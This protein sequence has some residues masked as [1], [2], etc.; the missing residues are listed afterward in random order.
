[1]EAG[2]DRLLEERE[3]ARAIAAARPRARGVEGVDALAE[4][5][6]EALAQLAR[7]LDRA[8]GVEPSSDALERGRAD[9]L[10]ALLRLDQADELVHPARLGRRA[11]DG[12]G[13][14]VVAAVDERLDQRGERLARRARREEHAAL[15]ERVRAH[16]GGEGLERGARAPGVA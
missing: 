3:G 6:E 8:R 13:H 10:A 4:A 12:V 16:A 14:R 1:R 7:E 15:E 5:R 11:R 2:V 9:A